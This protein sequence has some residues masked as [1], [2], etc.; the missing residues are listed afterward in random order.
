MYE[1]GQYL[2]AALKKNKIKQKDFALAMNMSQEHISKICL[3]KALPSMEAL[4]KMCSILN[5]SFSEFFSSSEETSSI[6][7][8]QDEQS[9]LIDYRHL[10]TFERK[11]IGTLV[12][13][14]YSGRK[15]DRKIEPKQH[16]RQVSGTA[17]AGVPLFDDSV[18]EFVPVPPK[19]IDS[20]RYLIVKAKGDSMEPDIHNGDY[21]IASLLEPNPFQGEFALVAIEGA[22]DDNEYTIK[23]F[24]RHGN[25]V[26][27]ESINDSYP[28]MCFD[29]Q[30]IKGAYRIAHIIHQG[31]AECL[32]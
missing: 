14:L 21:V 4:I 31:P 10:E 17:A 32:E 24:Y 26:T 2:R 18:D 11:A 7:V 20:K 13:S 19:Y 9:L 16:M 5:M 27:L 6:T 25:K 3:N 15:A 22:G 29:V 28:P 23:K 12:S 30:Q 1:I 8:S